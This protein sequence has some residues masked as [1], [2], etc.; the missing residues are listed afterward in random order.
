M[1]ASIY[2]SSIRTEPLPTHVPTASEKPIR[3]L[4][5]CGFV[6][7]SS[8]GRYICCALLSTA[9]A[10]RWFNWNVHTRRVWMEHRTEHNRLQFD[11]FVYTLFI[12]H[13][14]FGWRPASVQSVGRRARQTVNNHDFIIWIYVCSIRGTIAP[15]AR[16]H[17]V[18][19]KT[20]DQRTEHSQQKLKQIAWTERPKW[21][22][23]CSVARCGT[24]PCFSVDRKL[25]CACGVHNKM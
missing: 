2:E 17:S 24:L 16:E 8:C 25:L 18:W 3:I 6:A 20:K 14:T 11:N 13:H 22:F 5:D 19:F 23:Y 9:N 10:L 7:D 4:F 15:H 12:L 1:V 21:S